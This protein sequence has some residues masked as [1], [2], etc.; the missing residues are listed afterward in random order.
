M[1]KNYGNMETANI[2]LQTLAPLFIGGGENFKLNKSEYIFERSKN[3]VHVIDEKRFANYLSS[4]KLTQK[5]YGYVQ[6]NGR[7]LERNSFRPSGFTQIKPLFDWL[8][9]SGINDFSHF[10]KYSLDSS[11]VERI[12][13]ISCF[14]KDA[15]LMAY[16]PG[17]SIKGAIRTAYICSELLEGSQSL[18]R[19]FWP[20]LVNCL[21]SNS[22]A[23]YIN[24]DLQ[25]LEKEIENRFFCT[26]DYGGQ[27][28]SSVGKDFFKGVVVG[29]SAPISSDKLHLLP[30]LDITERKGEAKMLPLIREY[31]KPGTETEFMLTID[32][33]I[34]KGKLK[35]IED[36]L[37]KIAVFKE[38]IIGDEGI[39]N[40]FSNISYSN[41]FD[42]SM[43][44]DICIGGG[45]GFLTKTVIYALAPS[46]QEATDWI[47]RYLDIA[48]YDRKS[49]KPAHD[50]FK[51]DKKVAPRALKIANYKDYGNL[52]IGWCSL[53]VK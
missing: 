35:G 38:H 40:A 10:I 14:I 23:Y 51:Y 24:K 17:S 29:D 20:R 19:E 13:D 18:K 28:V 12:N 44:P 41:T 36:L 25:I 50:H 9:E 32:T 22:N 52:T 2:S 31:L 1:I 27:R 42:K 37:E 45:A 26:L 34:T 47:A 30:K 11:K 15:D 4:K 21:K 6:E 53:K 3:L 39:Y 48:F 16:F 5:Y 43:Q 49:N 33:S 46:R 8:K 7:I